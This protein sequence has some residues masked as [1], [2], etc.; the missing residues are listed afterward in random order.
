MSTNIYI[1]CYGCNIV[2][3]KQNVSAY[4]AF[5]HSASL[6]SRAAPSHVVALSIYFSRRRC[7]AISF[8]R[9]AGI[10]FDGRGNEAERN[11]GVIEL[12]AVYIALRRTT[13][14]VLCDSHDT[15][16]LWQLKL[17]PTWPIFY[18][19]KD[20]PYPHPLRTWSKGDHKTNLYIEKITWLKTVSNVKNY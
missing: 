7:R 10:T 20:S 8:K 4:N 1:Q 3:H 11:K 16:N 19:L 18:I 15:W 5:R 13:R 6:T 14:E 12:V 9:R 2:T 17:S